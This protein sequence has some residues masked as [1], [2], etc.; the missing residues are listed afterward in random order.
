MKNLTSKAY[1]AKLNES[2]EAFVALG[3]T[4]EEY[5]E[6]LYDATMHI[7]YSGFFSIPVKQQLETKANARKRILALPHGQ[8]ILKVEDRLHV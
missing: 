8:E 1:D 7:D 2:I 6:L 5:G 4:P 3:N